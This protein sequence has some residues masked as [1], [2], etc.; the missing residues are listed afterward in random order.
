MKLNKKVLS[1]SA[2]LAVVAILAVAGIQYYINAKVQEVK[3]TGEKV[4]KVVE[5]GTTKIAEKMTEVKD[6]TVAVAK[7]LNK[8]ISNSEELNATKT[9]I[10]ERAGQAKA[11]LASWLA[12]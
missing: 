9:E 3:E 2:S 11:K 7:D 12:K 6:E 4:V 8:T 1:V 10:K 5:T